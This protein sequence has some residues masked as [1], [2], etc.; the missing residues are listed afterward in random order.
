VNPPVFTPTGWCDRV[1]F[2]DPL[3]L[4][5]SDVFLRELISNANDALEKLRL[6]SL[7]NRDVWDGTSPLNITI[8]TLPAEDGS[9]G[10]IVITGKLF[11]LSSHPTALRLNTTDNGIG[12]TPDD[13]TRNLVRARL[14]QVTMPDPST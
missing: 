9:S 7:T 2:G 4:P 14:D 5:T 3:S 1:S 6:T 8:K 10:R 12:M 11:S 13:M